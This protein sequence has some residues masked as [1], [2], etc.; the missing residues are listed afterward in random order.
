LI[1]NCPFINYI[2][3]IVLEWRFNDAFRHSYRVSLKPMCLLL[4]SYSHLEYLF[5]CFC[6]FGDFILQLS[7]RFNYNFLFCWELLNYFFTKFLFVY[8][9]YLFQKFAGMRGPLKG[10]SNLFFINTLM[11]L[12]ASELSKWGFWIAL[13][14][15]SFC[16]IVL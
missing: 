11:A 10:L 15:L 7:L 1:S 13:V 12:I 4:F 9:F 8:V 5:I 3:F 16:L 2:I 14:A 6:M